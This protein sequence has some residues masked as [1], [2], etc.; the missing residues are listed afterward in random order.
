MNL[1]RTDVYYI[2]IFKHVEI[3]R[4]LPHCLCQKWKILAGHGICW[5]RSRWLPQFLQPFWTWAELY[6]RIEKMSLWLQVCTYSLYSHV[7]IYDNQSLRSHIV[8][9]F[10]LL[11]LDHKK[12]SKSAIT[13][14]F[15]FG[16][17]T[18]L[19][20]KLCF[21]GL[22]TLNKHREKKVQREISYLKD[23]ILFNIAA[24]LPL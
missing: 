24:A 1:K 20:L 19:R 23:F 21:I 17:T 16:T 6:V 15:I 14:W 4:P 22:C 7:K 8:M 11:W 12:R 18:C 2:E 10:W 13:L 3:I 9:F 5:K